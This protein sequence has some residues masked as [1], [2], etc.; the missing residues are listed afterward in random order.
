M[1]KKEL[2]E[3]VAEQTNT[4]RGHSRIIVET[5]MDVF[6]EIL[7]TEG[8]IEVRNFGVFNVKET[9]ERIGR[10]PVTKEEASVPARKIV[11]FKAGKMMKERVNRTPQNLKPAPGEG[12]QE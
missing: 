3:I 11:Q 4:K 6:M 8:R 1:T 10:N 7:A 9:P 12:W 2:V 5:A